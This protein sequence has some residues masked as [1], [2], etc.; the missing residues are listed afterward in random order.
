MGS[1]GC[2][3]FSGKIT[4]FTSKK[5]NFEGIALT[6]KMCPNMKTPDAF[7]KA[8]LEVKN[9]QRDQLVLKLYDEGNKELL[10]LKKVD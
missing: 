4:E 3:Q 1:D 5:I 7:N 6:R 8:L 2:N 10:Q 9:Y